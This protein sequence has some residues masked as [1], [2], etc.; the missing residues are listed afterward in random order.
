MDLTETSIVLEVRRSEKLDAMV[1]LL[2]KFKIVELVRTGK[3]IM[4]RGEGDLIREAGGQA[5]SCR[6][7]ADCRTP[8]GNTEVALRFQDGTDT[9]SNGSVR[10]CV[11]R[12]TKRAGG[13]ESAIG[14]I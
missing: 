11:E 9:Q 5:P 3:V 4:A 14:L 2:R 12:L 7:L 6:F 10:G 13:A 1:E 8:G